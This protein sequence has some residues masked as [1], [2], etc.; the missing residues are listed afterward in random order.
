[1]LQNYN[2]SYSCAV[3]R[4]PSPGKHLKPKLK[5]FDEKETQTFVFR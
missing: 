1:M 5:K 4:D 2:Q 3:S